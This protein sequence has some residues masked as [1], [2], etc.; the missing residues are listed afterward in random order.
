MF[1]S[2]SCQ[3]ER[4]WGVVSRFLS[5]LVVIQVLRVSSFS[6]CPGDHA[7]CPMVART[8][9]S[10]LFIRVAAV[11]A[12]ICALYSSPV[13]FFQEKEE[14]VSSLLESGP[15]RYTGSLRRGAKSGSVRRSPTV[16]SDLWLMIIPSAP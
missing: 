8:M 16:V 15:P 3:S 6:S 1:F 4:S 13:P 9:C 10:L 2:K 5:G 11:F 14:N 12:E 7:E